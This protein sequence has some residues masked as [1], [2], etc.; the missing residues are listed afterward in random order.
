[1]LVGEA[2]GISRK[3]S[4]HL[5]R[6][7]LP[8]IEIVKPQGYLGL[9]GLLEILV[10]F[11]IVAYLGG[12]C[13]ESHCLKFVGIFCVAGYPEHLFITEHEFDGAAEFRSLAGIIAVKGFIPTEHSVRESVEF[14]QVGKPFCYS[15]QI[16]LF[17]FVL[18]V[19]Y[20][21]FQPLREVYAMDAAGS[22]K[23]ISF[24]KLSCKV[25]AL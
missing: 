12:K 22:C 14:P 19:N 10:I 21:L 24:E 25:K 3:E 8:D 15:I 7:F 13:I 11:E 1:M 16:L 17:L 9:I 23:Q 6:A 20:G 5:P 18:P 2:A 4:E